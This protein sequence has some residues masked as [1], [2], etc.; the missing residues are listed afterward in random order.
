M[1]HLNRGLNAEFY[2]WIDDVRKAYRHKNELVEKLQFYE[3]RL[4][5]YNAVTYDSIRSSS[6]KNNV[7]DNLLYVIGKIDKVNERLNRAQKLIDKY[8]SIKNELLPQ[9]ICVLEYLVD[10]SLTKSE[11]AD[12]L[13]LSRTYVYKLISSIKTKRILF[14]R[15]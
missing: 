13:F 4:V 8:I 9:E 12:E 1:N 14:E 7:E 10:T 2:K 5:G 11:I 3:S 15:I 6:T